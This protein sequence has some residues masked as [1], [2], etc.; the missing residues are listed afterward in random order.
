MSNQLN[1]NP[2]M[3]KLVRE[4]GLGHWSCVSPLNHCFWVRNDGILTSFDAMMNSEISI[5]NGLKN[6]DVLYKI[7][8]NWQKPRQP[9]LAQKPFQYPC[10]GALYFTKTK[11]HQVKI[12]GF[13]GSDNEKI[14]GFIDGIGNNCFWYADTG[15]SVNP[16]GDTVI[17]NDLIM[18]VWE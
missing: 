11:K 9:T 15:K 17:S 13:F 5:I 10:N 12:T 2:E 18:F 4:H 8:E 16:F 7:G 3:D 14:T 1:I 6:T